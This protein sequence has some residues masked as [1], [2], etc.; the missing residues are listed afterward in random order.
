M[1]TINNA[2]A[3]A[4]AQQIRGAT[5]DLLKAF[6]SARKV[7]EVWNNGTFGMTHFSGDNANLPV[8]DG[9]SGVNGPADGRPVVTGY[10]LQ[11]GYLRLNDLVT[12]LTA[13]NNSK[14]NSLLNISRY[15]V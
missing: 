6:E 7:R 15:E 12:D 14:L 2:E 5:R 4:F 1:S 8:A 9:A 11:L 13:N 10:K 3:V